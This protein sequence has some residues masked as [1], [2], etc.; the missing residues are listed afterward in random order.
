[1]EKEESSKQFIGSVIL[2]VKVQN[3]IKDNF[4]YAKFTNKIFSFCFDFFKLSVEDN[5]SNIAQYQISAE[6]CFADISG[7]T[8]TLKE[9]RYLS[10]VANTHLLL[11][12]E[13]DLL[14][15]KLSIL[16]QLKELSAEKDDKE[17]SVKKEIKPVSRVSDFSK[18]YIVAGPDKLTPSKKKI[19]EY[20][21]SY[22]NKRTKDIIYEFN[23][24][25][26]RSVKR[27]LTDLLKAG[28]VKKRI[29]SKAV[30]YYANE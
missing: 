15:I 16:K 22:P 10:L 29:D 13:S 28:L 6:K 2:L 3:G 24:L 30:Y 18:S 7:L 12:A 4:F 19:L 9:L 25:S 11:K 5:S 23:A 26:G 1:M 21:K 20:I 27:N 8:D 17:E 14:T